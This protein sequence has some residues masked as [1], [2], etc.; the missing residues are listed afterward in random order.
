MEGRANIVLLMLMVCYGSMV[1]I[2][3]PCVNTSEGYTCVAVS[4]VGWFLTCTY[5]L[6]EGESSDE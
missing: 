2:A 4:V 5:A 1:K 3:K 6:W